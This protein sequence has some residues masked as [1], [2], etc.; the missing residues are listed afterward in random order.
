MD[1]VSW[2]YIDLF[3][4]WNK[5]T[6]HLQIRLKVLDDQQFI[7]MLMKCEFWLTSNVFLGDIF[8][9]KSIKV[10]PKKEDP[11][12]NSSKSLSP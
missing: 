12:K 2:R 5:Y 6:N 8:T 11:F 9:S 3:K 4:E 7:A 1:C 10:H